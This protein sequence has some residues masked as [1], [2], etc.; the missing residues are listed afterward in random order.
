MTNTQPTIDLH[1]YWDVLRTRKLAVII[2]TLAAIA[3]AAAYIFLQKPQYTAQAKVLVSPLLSPVAASTPKSSL[4]D[5]NTEQA[6]AAS[7]PVAN[8]ARTALKLSSSNGDRLLSHLSVS[9]ASTGNI[10]QFQYTALTR[11][12]P[13][14]M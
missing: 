12:R 1:Q 5:M 9:A 14:S 10:L 11:S 13:P 7:A 3:L 4:P 6:T 8:L 2:T